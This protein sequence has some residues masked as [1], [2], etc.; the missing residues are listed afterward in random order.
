MSSLMVLKQL[1]KEVN[2]LRSFR[3]MSSLMVLKLT[4]IIR[5]QNQ[6]F[7]SMSSLMVLKPLYHIDAL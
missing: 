2:K 4:L 7:R 6:S 1:I 5:E 3:S